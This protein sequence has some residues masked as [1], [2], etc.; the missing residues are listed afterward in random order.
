MFLFVWALKLEVV[1]DTGR[2][3]C[4]LSLSFRQFFSSDLMQFYQDVSAA[5]Q[6]KVLENGLN[7]SI[8]K[9]LSLV[10]TDKCIC[11]SSWVLCANSVSSRTC[12]T[13]SVYIP[14]LVRGGPLFNS[15]LCSLQLN[16]LYQV[17]YWVI[18]HLVP[19][20]GPYFYLGFSFWGSDC[21]K[22]SI[23][24]PSIHLMGFWA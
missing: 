18:T 9:H 23:L 12:R 10:W 15:L 22:L 14:T 24:A 3:I 5:L 17:S 2:D 13:G 11:G 20:T 8:L 21:W 16:L 19:S 7:Q 4:S 1:E 6:A